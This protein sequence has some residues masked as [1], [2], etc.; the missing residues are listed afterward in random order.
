[1]GDLG[2][3]EDRVERST[4]LIR[5]DGSIAKVWRKVKGPGHADEVLAAT[6]AL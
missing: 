6:K 3:T 4:F 5:P 1:M 2:R